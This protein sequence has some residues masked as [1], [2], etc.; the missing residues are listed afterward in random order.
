MKPPFLPARQQGKKILQGRR[1]APRITF[2]AP[3]F[4]SHSVV[5][6]G[7]PHLESPSQP[8]TSKLFLETQRMRGAREWGPQGCTY[9][10]VLAP[11]DPPSGLVHLVHVGKIHPVGRGARKSGDSRVRTGCRRP[12][13]AR[14]PPMFPEVPQVESGAKHKARSGDLKRSQCTLTLTGLRAP[15]L[16]LWAGR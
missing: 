15:V 4:P 5:T 6:M 12:I 2:S 3:S 9:L 14:T 11:F 1:D 13:D 16:A 7:S 10:A 8:P